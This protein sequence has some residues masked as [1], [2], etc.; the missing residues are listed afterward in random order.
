MRVVISG[1]IGTVTGVLVVVGGVT[2]YTNV[3]TTD[4]QR[5]SPTSVPYADE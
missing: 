4:T 1:V 2:T 5:T 3:S